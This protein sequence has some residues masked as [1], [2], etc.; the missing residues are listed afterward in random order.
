M[1]EFKDQIILA[2][3]R[4]QEVIAIAVGVLVFLLMWWLI[5]RRP[6]PRVECKWRRDRSGQRETLTKWTCVKCGADAFTATTKR[7]KDCKS[8]LKPKAL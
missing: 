5:V 4:Y 3:L 2:T 1:Q 7:P 6:R 8:H